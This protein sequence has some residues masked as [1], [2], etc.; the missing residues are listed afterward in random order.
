[1]TEGKLKIC[2]F[3]GCGFKCCDFNV[4]NYIVMHPGE[5]ESTELSTSHLEVLDDDYHGGKKVVCKAKNCADCDNGYK[6]LDCQTYPLFPIV[7]EGKISGAWLKGSKCPL[8]KE[9]LPIAWFNSIT[10]KWNKAAC[11]EWI[12]KVD[13]VGYEKVKIDGKIK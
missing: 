1:M 7:K 13:L 10:D 12:K 11:N 6:P 5:Y 3:M 4:G 8:Q 2:P 9:H